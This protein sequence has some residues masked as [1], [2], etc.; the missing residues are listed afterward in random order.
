M[1]RS[2]AQDFWPREPQRLSQYVACG[3]FLHL[4]QG[5]GVGEV[6][7]IERERE[8]GAPLQAGE[9]GVEHVLLV[10]LGVA[11]A[12]WFPFWQASPF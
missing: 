4:E 8:L 9:M 12:S 11:D 5:A 2:W 7:R 1:S 3:F 10:G 6:E